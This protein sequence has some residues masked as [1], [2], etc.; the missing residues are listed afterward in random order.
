MKNN[1]QKMIKIL[2]F[3]QAVLLTQSCEKMTCKDDALTI[4]RVDNNSG[5]LRLDGYYYGDISGVNAE[6]PN[7]YLFYQNGIFSNA[8]SYSLSDAEAGNVTLNFPE[9]KYQHKGDWGVY[10]IDGNNIEIEYWVSRSCGGVGL[11]YE[12]GKILNDT[13]FKITYW[14]HS[15]EGRT[16]QEKNIEAIFKF[17]GYTPKPDST[18]NFIK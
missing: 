17:K 3:I 9:L 15:V 7:I 2:F 11:L 12:S 10:K 5:K 14:R 16:K 1:I 6:Y 13:T 8:N 4:A 18:N